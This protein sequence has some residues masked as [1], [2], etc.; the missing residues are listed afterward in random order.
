MDLTK[1]KYFGLLFLFPLVIG[2]QGE[3]PDSSETNFK[4]AG[5]AGSYAYVSRG[6]AGEVLNKQ[7][8]PYADGG[9]SI[10][11]KFKFPL[12]IGFRGG[13]IREHS[14][15]SW[16][17]AYSTDE[18]T[19]NFYFNPDM[20]LDW[21]YFGI[22][23]GFFSSQKD[24]Y[25]RDIGPAR[26]FPSGHIRIGSPRFYFLA[27]LMES[28]PLYSGGGYLNLGLGGKVSRK[29][30]YW[31]GLGIIGPYD[32]EGFLV[33]TDFEFAKN[34]QLNLAGRWGG[35]QGISENAVSL[36]LS[37]RIITK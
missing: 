15:T 10:D 19:N 22:G 33:K 17:Q 14:R 35:S 1:L 37:Y 11:H 30:S 36:G 9:F 27:H 29:V 18:R 32:T 5:G 25:W 6:C 23:A 24:L 8:I 12:R 21:K 31:L 2:V 13:Y 20:A 34:W 4:L 3:G 28:V 26:N 16:E 7:K